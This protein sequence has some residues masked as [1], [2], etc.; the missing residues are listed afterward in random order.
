MRVLVNFVGKKKA[1]LLLI[2]QKENKNIYFLILQIII[3]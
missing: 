2:I 3:M 1:F